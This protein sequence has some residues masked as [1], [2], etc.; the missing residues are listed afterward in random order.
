MTLRFNMSGDGVHH[1]RSSRRRGSA[2][3]N[4]G[5]SE[6]QEPSSS[7]G[8][9]SKSSSSSRQRRPRSLGR[10]E[11]RKLR[12]ERQKQRHAAAAAAAMDP[13]GG[14]NDET[15]VYAVIRTTKEDREKMRK[16]SKLGMMDPVDMMIQQAQERARQQQQQQQGEP[17]TRSTRARN[18]RQ[19]MALSKSGGFKPPS[20]LHLT[21][22]E[23]ED[24]D[25]G[26]PETNP[27]REH[28]HGRRRHRSP[29]HGDGVRR[30]KSTGDSDMPPPVTTMYVV[31]AIDDELEPQ[32]PSSSRTNKSSN[33][34]SRKKKSRPRSMD[35]GKSFFDELAEEPKKPS[36]E[37]LINP[38]AE[39]AESN[40]FLHKVIMPTDES[41]QLMRQ[42]SALGL[43]DPVFGNIHESTKPHHPSNIF[44]D[45]NYEDVPDD[46]KDIMSIASDKTDPMLHL[47][48]SPT[49]GARNHDSFDERD[50]YG[51][52]S[53]KPFSTKSLFSTK[54]GGSFEGG[55]ALAPTK[56]FSTKS[57]FSTKSGGSFE[58]GDAFVPTKPFSAR[59]LFSTKSGGSFEGGDVLGPSSS[60]KKKPPPPARFSELAK[61]S[62]LK[63]KNEAPLPDDYVPPTG[64]FRIKK[65][66]GSSNMH[67]SLSGGL[68]APIATT[69]KGRSFRHSS[70]NLHNS[71]NFDLTGDWHNSNFH[72]SFSKDSTNSGSKPK[73][74]RTFSNPAGVYVPPSALPTPITRSKSEQAGEGSRALPSIEG[75]FTS[76]VA[77]IKVSRKKGAQEVTPEKPVSK[78][79]L[80]PS[81]SH[82][83]MKKHN[84]TRSWDS[85][86]GGSPEVGGQHTTW[87]RSVRT[88]S[89][90][91]L[92]SLGNGRDKQRE[93]I[94]PPERSM[95]GSSSKDKKSRSSRRRRAEKEKGPSS[96]R[97]LK[98]K[99][100]RDN[101]SSDADWPDPPDDDW[102]AGN[103]APVVS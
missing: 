86:S 92:D 62:N 47:G 84:S 88:L 95:S 18:R 53:T 3:G 98:K 82:L 21:I 14:T 78:K 73:G 44:E 57:L 79:K 34:N 93:P 27:P 102:F 68:A 29:K 39:K 61:K 76:G 4:N 43:E 28:S 74:E 100:E 12:R 35:L 11:E 10:E 45:M 19:E 48:D 55:D 63:G 60:S 7:K 66:K 87:A 49:P 42:V 1:H 15:E 97:S 81:D 38:Q 46:M 26:L 9:N 65:T 51:G 23:D 37:K 25:K 71:L 30:N 50:L 32:K 13:E 64:S 90:D 69:E 16:V 5:Q 96:S 91:S 6:S 83:K 94:S 77:A 31:D 40:P 36:S 52:S 58:G 72:D 103:A 54:S 80:P 17:A 24:E 56:P 33:S 2:S 41:K 89:S 85:D 70:G 8:R 67:M 99:Q 75:I 20:Q 22:E 101:R 59:S